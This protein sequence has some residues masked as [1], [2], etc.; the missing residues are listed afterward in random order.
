MRVKIGTHWFLQLQTS[1]RSAQGG[2]VGRGCHRLSSTEP[3]VERAGFQGSAP[4]VSCNII[5]LNKAGCLSWYVPLQWE[6]LPP[7]T[8]PHWGY[9]ASKQLS[10]RPRLHQSV[11]GLIVLAQSLSWVPRMVPLQMPCSQN[12]SDQYPDVSQVFGVTRGQGHANESSEMPSCQTSSKDSF[13]W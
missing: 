9:K 11:L 12:T 13:Q 5:F 10:R 6:T 7:A 8:G 2:V 3:A 1:Y 4:G